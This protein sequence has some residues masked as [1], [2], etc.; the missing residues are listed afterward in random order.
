MIPAKTT[1]SVTSNLGSSSL[2]HNPFIRAH[3]RPKIDMSGVISTVLGCTEA[4]ARTIQ[5]IPARINPDFSA[6]PTPSRATSTVPRGAKLVKLVTSPWIINLNPSAFM[7]LMAT[8][9]PSELRP[10]APSGR[11][12][13]TDRLKK[14]AIPL[15]TITIRQKMAN[16]VTGCGSR[17]PSHSTVRRNLLNH[18]PCGTSSYS[19]RISGESAIGFEKLLWSE[20]ISARQN[21]SPFEQSQKA[22]G[23]AHRTTPADTMTY[24]TTVMRRV[25]ENV[26]LAV[27][28]STR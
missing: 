1:A 15:A 27:T 2:L 14:S 7:R 9:R 28:A 13:T 16:S 12:S 8:I 4:A 11:G 3:K 6:T 17:L 24:R 18:P 22:A 26:P 10:A 21:T 23:A 25:S 20:K 5:R 19:G